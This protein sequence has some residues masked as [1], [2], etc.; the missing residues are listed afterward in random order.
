MEQ[1]VLM[2]SGEGLK[3]VQSP[4]FYPSHPHGAIFVFM[5]SKI[6]RASGLPHFT[7]VFHHQLF[8]Y[9]PG[10]SLT[11]AVRETDGGRSRAGVRQRSLGPG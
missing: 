5:Y 1:N 9:G 3:A 4:P 7:I 2:W 10:D 8:Q 6:C 11:V